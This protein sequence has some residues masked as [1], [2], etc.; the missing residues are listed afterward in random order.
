MT[1]SPGE[2]NKW[3]QQRLMGGF[4][5]DSRKAFRERIPQTSLE[6][7]EE[8]Q[9]GDAFNYESYL[10]KKREED[11]LE[12]MRDTVERA[13]RQFSCRDKNVF[14][15]YYY[16]GLKASEIGKIVNLSES[17]V[18]QLLREM[19][20]RIKMFARNDLKCSNE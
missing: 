12:E 6:E 20:E 3:L 10:S 2:I 15:M 1:R 18:S 7:Y 16:D 14:C 17:R 11:A 13:I 9:G 5:D 8:T 4:L 19:R